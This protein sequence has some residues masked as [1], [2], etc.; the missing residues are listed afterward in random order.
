MTMSVLDDNINIALYSTIS[1]GNGHEG[2]RHTPAY[3]NREHVAVS[4]R[5]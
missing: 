5:T 3:C 2:L 4:H 1:L